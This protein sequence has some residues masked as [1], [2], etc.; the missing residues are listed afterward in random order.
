[1]SEKCVLCGKKEEFMK[2]DD[3]GRPLCEEHYIEKMLKPHWA[4]GK[5][6]WDIFITRLGF[7]REI[8]TPDNHTLERINNTKNQIIKDKQQTTLHGQIKT[9]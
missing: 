8:P 2:H 1:M 6:Q 7:K 9:R 5:H 4:R 3:F